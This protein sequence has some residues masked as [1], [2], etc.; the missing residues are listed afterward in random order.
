MNT[1]EVTAIGVDTPKNGW[2]RSKSLRERGCWS[3]RQWFQ[4]WTC[5]DSIIHPSAFGTSVTAAH[6]PT[7]TKS[8]QAEQFIACVYAISLLTEK[9]TSCNAA[10]R[11]H[12][13][14]D[15]DTVF[16]LSIYLYLTRRFLRFWRKACKSEKLSQGKSGHGWN[17]A[18]R[19]S[20]NSIT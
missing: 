10:S 7:T 2:I 17:V 18:E 19:R 9:T 14:P 1:H 6:A 20:G 16:Y 3:L 4:R 15:V 13:F 5:P 11:F 12:R 8:K